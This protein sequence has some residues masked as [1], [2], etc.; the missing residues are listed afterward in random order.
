[1]LE[2]AAAAVSTAHVE[3]TYLIITGENDSEAELTDFVSWTASLSPEI[4]V[5]FSR[6]FPQY[7][8]DSPLT[9]VE[10]MERAVALARKKLFWVYSGNLHGQDDST[11]C[12]KCNTQLI[13]RAGYVVERV[14]IRDG[15]C[16]Q[17]GRSVP[18][19]F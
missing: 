13:A 9:P 16:P 19:K 11:Y 15:K 10:T 12:P 14:V 2:T 5:H 7:H 3:L 6:Y 18:G 1:V 4:P 17:C 8:R